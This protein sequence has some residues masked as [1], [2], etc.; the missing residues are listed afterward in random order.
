MFI[1]DIKKL[2]TLDIIMTTVHLKCNPKMN[3]VLFP[4]TCWEPKIRFL[5]SRGPFMF[6]KMIPNHHGNGQICFS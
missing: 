2:V 6:S 5:P 4:G 3:N 1:A